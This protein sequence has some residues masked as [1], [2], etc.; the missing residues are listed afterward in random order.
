MFT[1]TASARYQAHPRR[2]WLAI[3]CFLAVGF[4][5]LLSMK[6]GSTSAHRRL[7]LGGETS[8]LIAIST[9]MSNRIQT[10]K[11]G[12]LFSTEAAEIGKTLIAD[13]KQDN[14]HRLIRGKESNLI[15]ISARM[16]NRILTLEKA[17]SGNLFTSAKAAEIGKT[18]IADIR[19]DD[20]NLWRYI[21]I[22]EKY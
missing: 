17:I 20:A 16:D 22:H 12:N 4:L 21:E 14:D 19:Q 6:P 8:D 5:G 7:V 1:Q 10:L 15:A 9:R 3:G 18:L 2:M 13:I 11:S